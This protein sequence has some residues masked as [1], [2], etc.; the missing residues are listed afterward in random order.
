MLRGFERRVF[1]KKFLVRASKAKLEAPGISG[2]N[3]QPNPV[4][5]AWMQEFNVSRPHSALADRT[6]AEFASQIPVN[7]YLDEPKTGKKLTI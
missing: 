7:C 2:P 1:F 6:P 4:I 5:E 3:L